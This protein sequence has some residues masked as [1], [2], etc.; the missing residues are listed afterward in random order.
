M[1]NE[2][3]L[4]RWRHKKRGT[5]YTFLTIAEMQCSS[6]PKFDHTEVVVY[7]GDDGH[8]WV[9]PKDEFFDGRFEAINE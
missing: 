7:Q 3:T 9:R 5:E 2:L 6:D 4:S 8:L 1:S